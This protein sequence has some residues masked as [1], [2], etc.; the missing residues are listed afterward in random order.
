MGGHC[1]YDYHDAKYGNVPAVTEAGI[2]SRFLDQFSDAMIGDLLE[3]AD[4]NASKFK[5]YQ[6]MA[7]KAEAVKRL[8]K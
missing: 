6:T 3:Q 5:V 4:K 2:Y 7:I 8:K 1:D